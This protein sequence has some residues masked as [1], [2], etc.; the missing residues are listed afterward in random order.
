MAHK[1][2]KKEHKKWT[3]FFV[4]FCAFLWLK[5]MQLPW[6]VLNPIEAPERFQFKEFK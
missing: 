4:L 3:F 6:R 2:H 5:N 1:R